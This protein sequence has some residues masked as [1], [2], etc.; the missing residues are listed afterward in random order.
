[1]VCKPCEGSM[2]A[3]DTAVSSPM[4]GR[5]VAKATRNL[6]KVSVMI[7]LLLLVTGCARLTYDVTPTAMSHVAPPPTFTS[8][9]AGAPQQNEPEIELEVEA[10]APTS[11]VEGPAAMRVDPAVVNVDVG[12]TSLVKVNIENVVGLH[13][14]E[15][16]IDFE[17]RYVQIED[18][19]PDAEGVQI[20]A[21]VLPMPVQ[22]VQNEA[23]NGAGRIVYHVAQAPGSPVSGSG[24]VASFMVRGIAEGGS[25]LRFSVVNLRDAEG[26]PLPAPEQVDG[27]VVVGAGVAEP[28]S[29]ATAPAATAPAPVPT[30]PASTTRAYHTV[31][32]GEN[33][34]RIALRYGTTVD[35]IVAANN[36]ANPN[37]VQV[38]QKLLI[39]AV[40]PAGQETYVVQPGDTLYSIARRHGT[41]VDALAALNQIGP[42]YAISVGQVLV[43][44]P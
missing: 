22:V 32:P 38:G 15:L 14:V 12:E 9:T 4:E 18:A 30:S 11:A 21:G 24:M 43:V 7:G 17:P 34:F 25:P 2:V 1:M 28:G 36:L 3:V 16:Q 41:T 27:M 35:A 20:G 42:P 40:S 19:D 5:V 39:P 13:S 8:A 26:Q 23:D 31:Q 29:T 6:R 10:P 37:A 33:L 44:G